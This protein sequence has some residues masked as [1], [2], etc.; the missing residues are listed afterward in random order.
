[1]SRN[2]IGVASMNYD[3]IYFR[4]QTFWTFLSLLV[5]ATVAE[6]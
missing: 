6:D 2:Q 5:A 4:A 1:M 3:E